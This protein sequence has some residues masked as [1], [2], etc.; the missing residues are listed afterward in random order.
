MK[1]TWKS[2]LTRHFNRIG[3]RSITKQGTIFLNEPKISGYD[4]LFIRY[5]AVIWR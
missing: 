2:A 5:N 3:S 1:E 4:S